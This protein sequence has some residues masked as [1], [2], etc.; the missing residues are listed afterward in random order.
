MRKFVG[1]KTV[2]SVINSEFNSSL[3]VENTLKKPEVIKCWVFQENSEGAASVY[4]L[5]FIRISVD[6]HQVSTI[7]TQQDKQEKI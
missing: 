1:V 2:R 7:N 4:S 6:N 5:S 3:A